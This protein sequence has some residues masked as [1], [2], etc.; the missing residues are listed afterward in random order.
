MGLAIKQK[1]EIIGIKI[2][3]NNA[4]GKV[5][6]YADDTTI[7]VKGKDSVSEVMNVVKEFCKGSGSK[8][9]EEKTVYMRFGKAVVLMGCFNFKEVEQIKIL[10]ILM[11]KN[12]RKVR[13]D[14]GGTSN[15]YR[16]KVTFLEIENNKLEGEGFN[17]EC[18]NGF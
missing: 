13:D 8:I 10:G 2:E 15:R 9:N 3:E 18:F 12:E 7:I 14:V 4:E 5:F 11:G 17:I 16:K 6:Q 1:E